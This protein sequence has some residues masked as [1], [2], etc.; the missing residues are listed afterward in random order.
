MDG[1]TQTTLVLVSAERAGGRGRRPDQSTD[2][3]TSLARRVHYNYMLHSTSTVAVR[4]G[5]GGGGDR[6]S[7]AQARVAT[8]TCAAISAVAPAD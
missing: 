7:L 4:L 3:P 1:R 8:L 2:R 6:F 5:V